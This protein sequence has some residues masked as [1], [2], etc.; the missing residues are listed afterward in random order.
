MSNSTE[1]GLA[2]LQQN[3]G[4]PAYLKDVD[5]KALNQEASKGTGG[6]ESP[7]RISIK[8][9]RFRLIVGGEQ[10]KVFDENY[11]DVV[12]LRANPEASK[13]FFSGAYDPNAEDKMPAC[14]SDNGVHPSPNVEN[15]VSRWC[16]NC[17]KAAWG[18]AISKVSGKKIK[19][20]D[21]RKRIAVVPAAK[22]TSDAY[23]LSIPSASLTEF[24]QFL[25]MLGQVSP[26]VPY[27]ALVVRLSFD[28]EADYPKL[29]FT[30]QRYLTDE[31]Y[32]EVRNRYESDEVKK[33]A[34][35][36]DIIDPPPADLKPVGE[37]GEPEQKKPEPE[38]EQA[39]EPEMSEEEREARRKAEEAQKA[40]EQ[41][42]DDWGGAAGAAVVVETTT[43]KAEEIP[44]T[45]H[46]QTEPQVV[47]DGSAV[48]QVFQGWDD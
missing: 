35:I 38:P 21:D 16:K 10:V 30:P 22:V 29:K 5:A 19:A 48:D 11:L 33:A 43:K 14:W 42:L 7:N 26:A 41:A 46:E 2:V 20:C 18:S 25:R 23:Q 8:A 37:V 9:S 3:G 36:T 4:L 24:G 40:K 34:T 15:P 27:N 1:Q 13:V 45:Q 39:K 17:P 12:M 47:E 31:E 6:G 32:A 28:T 44:V